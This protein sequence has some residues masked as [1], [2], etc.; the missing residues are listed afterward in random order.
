PQ[1]RAGILRVPLRIATAPSVSGWNVQHSIGAE[2]NVS[3]VVIGVRLLDGEKQLRGGHLC[4]IRV[5]G[6]GA[7]PFDA[8]V[9]ILTRV[10]DVQVAVCGILRV[11]CDAQQP[12]L[13]T[14]APDLPLDVEEW[15]RK[16]GATAQDANSPGLLHD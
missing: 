3:A 13:V 5:G 10:I 16:Q 4:A 8:G 11:E 15:S 14:A 7:V 2:E 6:A 9:S 1:E 12:L